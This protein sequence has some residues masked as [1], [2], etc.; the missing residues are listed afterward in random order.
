MCAIASQCRST[1]QSGER[2]LAVCGS[3]FALGFLQ[4]GPIYEEAL[5]HHEIE[6]FYIG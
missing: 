4:R 5:K 1:I 3:G 6:T 2:L